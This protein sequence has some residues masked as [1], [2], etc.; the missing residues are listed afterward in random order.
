MSVNSPLHFERFVHDANKYFKDLTDQIG[1]ADHINRVFIIWRAVMHTLRDRIHMGESLDL[2]SQLPM[3]LKG[4]YIENWKYHEH[5]PLK[6][7]TLEEMSTQVENLQSKYGEEEFDWDISTEELIKAILN[8]LKQ[9][10][11]DHQLDHLKGQLP[12]EVKSIIETS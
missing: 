12:E 6:Y 5:A 1:P 9:Y 3:I 7:E 10:L 11:S 4:F 2:V 8:S